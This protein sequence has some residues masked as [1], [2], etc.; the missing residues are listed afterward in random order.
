MQEMSSSAWERRGS[1]VVFDKTT[2]GR[3]IQD[4]AM[5]SLRDAMTWMNSWPATPPNGAS[6]VIVAGLE[7]CLDLD[8]PRDAE[9][10]LQ[11]RVKPFIEEF[12]RHWDQCGL[13]FGFGVSGSA[14]SVTSADE[15]VVFTRSDNKE[16]HLSYAL[17][18]GSSTLNVTRLVRPGDRP[19]EQ[20]TIGYYVRRIS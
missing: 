15:E 17:W 10:W 20:V 12:Q 3:L 16:V 8:T 13:V 1:S 4:Q 19:G 2:L 6:T 7:A 9:L 14:F 5:V 18:N 11:N